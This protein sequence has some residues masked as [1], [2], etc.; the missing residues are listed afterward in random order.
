M[1]NLRS[2]TSQKPFEYSELSIKLKKTKQNK[3]WHVILLDEGY[4][5]AMKGWIWLSTIIRE[6]GAK[7]PHTITPAVAA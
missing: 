6:A 7:Y 1:M 5:V 3:T 2:T 4:T